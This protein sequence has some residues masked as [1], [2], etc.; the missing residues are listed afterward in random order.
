MLPI[1]PVGGALLAIAAASFVLLR[2]RRRNAKLPYPPG[3]KGY[4]V[5][6]NVL[7]IPQGA[8]LWTA[9]IP[10]AEE[11]SERFPLQ[12]H[13]RGLM[14]VGAGSDILYLNFL[15]ADH[16][17]LNSSEAIL[18]LSD[19]RSGI[20]SGRVSCFRIHC[21]SISRLS[22]MIAAGSDARA[23]SHRRFASQPRSHGFS[24]GSAYTRGLSLFQTTVI[25]GGPVVGFSTNFS[26]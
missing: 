15:G 4:P 12:R 11:Y 13:G 9:V 8:Q 14:S 25:G 23:V 3:P 26:T 16:I 10:M 18:D 20:Y 1:S 19:K 5:I 24:E 6:G 7:D 22:R 17:I 21:P 2:R